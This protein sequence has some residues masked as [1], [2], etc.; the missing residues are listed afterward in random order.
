[1]TYR[2]NKLRAIRFEHPDYIPMGFAI[3][4][5]IFYSYD[6]HA[7]EELLE[8]HPIVAGKHCMR[9]D[10]VEKKRAEDEQITEFDDA[11]G[12]AWKGVI[13]GIRGVVQKH[14][15]ADLSLVPL[16]LRVFLS[17]HPAS[18]PSAQHR[19]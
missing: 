17:P 14:P 2:E 19:T 4:E 9:W 1:M 7:L 11:F 16:H 8:S 18:V 13:D 3:S 5:S 6:P 10:L 12:V 15:L